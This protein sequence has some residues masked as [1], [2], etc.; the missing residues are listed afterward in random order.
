MTTKGWLVKCKKA[1]HTPYYRLYY[2]H[3]P[4]LRNKDVGD[5][6]ERHELRKRLKCKSFKWFLDNIIPGKFILDEG[7]IGFGAVGSLL[8]F[9]TNRIC[10]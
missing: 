2:L 10:R 7:V 5:L 3:R 1:C 9:V 4:D 6:T 8:L